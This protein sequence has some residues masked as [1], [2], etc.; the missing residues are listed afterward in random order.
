[1][2]RILCIAA[3]CC[4]VCLATIGCGPKGPELGSVTGKV[5]LDGKP[6]TNGLVTFM[7]AA[8]GRPA[9]GK[10]N[11][12]GQYELLG[13]DGKG[14]LL[15]QHRVTVT[16]LQEVVAAAE[17]SSDSPEY[18]KQAVADPSDYDSAAVVEPI[19]ARYNTNTE[20]TF[21]VKSGSNVIDLE[22]KSE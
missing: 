15:G 5:T 2:R 8:G 7:P 12:S 10:T 1:M 13:V 20:L 17:M 19:P 11:T 4:L 18:A 22:L 14:A 6:V 21:E 3:A 16:T 9:T